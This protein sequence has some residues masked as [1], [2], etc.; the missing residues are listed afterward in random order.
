MYLWLLLFRGD[1][2]VCFSTPIVSLTEVRKK[3]EAKI[4]G[5]KLGAPSG[6]AASLTHTFLQKIS[7]KCKAKL[8]RSQY[9]KILQKMFGCSSGTGSLDQP[10]RCEDFPAQAAQHTGVAK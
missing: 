1:F 5:D 3:S 4:N 9:A 10:F 6:S 7:R 2:L 8:E